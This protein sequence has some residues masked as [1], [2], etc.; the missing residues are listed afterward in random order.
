[1]LEATQPYLCKNSP[2]ML[3]LEG[4]VNRAGLRNV[5]FALEHICYEKASHIEANWQDPKSAKVWTRSARRC[6]NVAFKVTS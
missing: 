1:M 5:L 2:A 3:V 6:A 4:I